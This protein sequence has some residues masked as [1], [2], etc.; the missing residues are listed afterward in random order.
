VAD[1]VFSVLIG[2]KAGEGV[3]KAAQVLAHLAMAGGKHVFQADDYQSLIK[4]GHNFSIVSISNSKL[5]NSYTDIDLIISF[6]DRSLRQHAGKLKPEG[7]HFVNGDDCASSDPGMIKLPL[8]SL[9]KE[10]YGAKGNVSLSAIAIFCAL[11]GIGLEQLKQT[12]KHEFK[13]SIAENISYATTVYEQV[14]ELRPEQ[15]IRLPG[16]LPSNAKL[17]TGNQLIALGAWVAGLDLYFSYPMTPAS[18]ILH[19]LA[20]KRE[21]HK[22][23]AVHAESE[24][25]AAN[26][27]VGACFA[28]K[29]CAVGS[30]GGGFALMQ[31][32]FSLAGM[33]E[34]PLLFV[35]SSRPGPATGV[36]TYTAQE[37]LFFAL[38]QG[39]GEFPRIVASPDSFERA[40]SLAAELM[41]LAW[42]CQSPA[43]LLTEKHLSE[44]SGDIRLGEIAMPDARQSIVAEAKPYK[45]YAITD[46]GVSPLK[47]P[48]AD[49]CDEDDVIKWNS[50]E[51]QESGVRTDAAEA[52]VMMKDKRQ[53]KADTVK[54][55]TGKYQRIAT[56]GEGD[57][58]V[59]A[60]GSTALEL[61]EA[62]N[63]HP[64]KLVV[65]IYLEPF[66]HEELEQY[67]GAEAIIVEHASQP[68]FAEFLRIKLDIIA[69]A[70][71]L[72]YDGRSWDS[73]DLAERVREAEHA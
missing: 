3:K 33:V 8:G 56:Y 72:R 9:M 34:A 37:D 6:D 25:A 70:N 52:M 45:R 65:P 2:G 35:L 1:R 58:L 29:R 51:H 42:E 43:I 26:M 11:S 31:E 16:L 14:T 13:H 23:Y 57:C 17:Y 40:F 50:H 19:Y 10:V 21:S 15:A 36:S 24:L 5:Y 60:Y 66:P 7:M 54:A 69:K 62:M 49:N 73:K 71:I 61:R 59:F 46:S 28:G 39:H 18:S 53:R 47:F 22:V 68:N 55:A 30:S 38:N 41:D 12:I 32:A 48:G 4:G 27:A 63:H 64:F 67:R 20:L 44:S